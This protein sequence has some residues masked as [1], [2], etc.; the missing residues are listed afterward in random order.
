MICEQ[1]KDPKAERSAAVE[2][3][4]VKPG[5]GLDLCTVVLSRRVIITERRSD[6]LCCQIS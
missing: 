6:T 3:L 5:S 4:R 2:P 1:G